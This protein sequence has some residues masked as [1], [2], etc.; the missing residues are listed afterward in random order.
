M[1]MRNP[2]M[3]H[4]NAEDIKRNTTPDL[5]VQLPLICNEEDCHVTTSEP[6]ASY[7]PVDE[8]ASVLDPTHGR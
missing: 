1:N 3:P 7:V 6:D 8:P 5:A 2:E 4:L